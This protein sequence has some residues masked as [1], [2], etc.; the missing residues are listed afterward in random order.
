[1]D[2]AFPVLRVEIGV[3]VDADP[4][5]VADSILGLRDD[6]LELDVETVDRAGLR[7]APA[8]ARGPAEGT[9]ALIVTLSD[10]AVLVALTHVLR[11]WV[12]RDRGRKVTI[13]IGKDSLELT[14]ASEQEQASLVRA[15]LDQHA[16]R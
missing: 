4:E 13:R 9:G 16:R 7:P 11:S 8:G 12:S 1:V 5:E 6:L 15:W 14:R 3:V 10:S 2:S